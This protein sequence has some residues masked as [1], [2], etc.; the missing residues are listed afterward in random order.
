M[1]SAAVLNPGLDSLY[2][3]SDVK[4]LFFT[5][6][7]S[8]V[9]QLE[10][11]KATVQDPVN[12]E[13]D[14]LVRSELSWI[15]HSNVPD[16]IR[17]H[18]APAHIASFI[19][20]DSL[21]SVGIQKTQ[22]LLDYRKSKLNETTVELR[23]WMI[24]FI[25]LSVILLLYTI[26]NLFKQK[27]KTISKEKEL[28][29]VLNRISDGVVSV[30]N[31]WR[32]TFLNDAAMA[33]H[34][35][36]KEETLGK[37]IWDVH[38]GMKGTIFWDKYHEALHENKVVEIHDYYP[39]MDIWFSVK[40]YPSA[41]GLTIFYKDITESKKAEQQLTQ[42]LKE[43]T[44]YKFALDESSIVAITDQ[45]GII[46]HAND[47]F[48]KISKY[49]REELIGQDHRII[50]SGHHPKEFIRNLWVTIAH[51]KIWKG[52]LKNKAKDGTIYW[53]DTTIVPFLDESGKPYQY[54]AIRAD[55]TE[56]KNV[57]DN[58]ASSEMHFRSLI[59]NSAEGISLTDE[60]AN[61]IYRSP[62]AIKIMGELPKEKTINLAHPDDL[63]NM[64]NI[65]RQ[66]EA[67]P[68]IPFAF[69]CRFP[70]ASGHYVWLEG[71][72]TNLL[73]TKGVNAI[74]TNFRDITQRKEDEE[75][76]IKSEKI[77]KAI[78]SSIPGSVICLLDP[79]YRYLLIEGDMLEKLGYSKEVL[80]GNKAGDVLPPEIFENAKAD[81]KMVLEGKTI[82]RESN[83]LGY[84]I[85]SRLI[86]LKDDH[87]SVYAIMTV[88]IDVTQLKNAQRSI[89]ELN[90]DL[91]QKIQV[92]TTELKK[93]NE[94]LEAFSYS[95]SHD[96]RAPLRAIMGY[97]A[98][99][100]EDYGNKL[101]TEAKEII[102]VIKASSLKMGRLIDDL[103]A[104]SRMG[105]KEMY[106]TI[107]DSGVMVNEVREEI[108]AQRKKNAH[109]HW[110]IR[111][112]PEMQADLNMIRLVW[113]NLISN[114][115]KYTGNKDQPQIEIGAGRENGQTVFYV[116]D[117][118]AGFDELYKHKLFKVFQRLHNENEFEG[119]GVGLALVE[120]IISKHGGKVWAEGKEN[121]GASFYFSL[122][123]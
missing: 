12:E 72:L 21:I 113:I 45:K 111:P 100:E 6:S 60:F 15:I 34:P 16:S 33:T 91:E 69:Q 89:S 55:I 43:V 18:R 53:V 42:T 67:N 81:L 123:D 82:T 109:I 14:S 3:S 50:N 68:G 13:L 54:V 57:E 96:L 106:K 62:A 41:D 86:P 7:Q 97:A 115:V 117:N 58:L 32:Y 80:L 2:R 71:T 64:K 46:K 120:R 19:S 49:P 10:I 110:D 36:S 85:I 75:K 9:R 87:N 8:I 22:S 101:A 102:D 24:L 28:E 25:I 119:T 35:L 118:G 44:D 99:L 56:R 4:K 40:V 59:E 74:V 66:V 107:V 104:F 103:L 5:D 94:E 48:C 1:E 73:Q 92:R 105:K 116:K 76:L 121:E 90:R 30:D 122:P 70:H 65:Q 31:D 52:E 83:R 26:I 108:V 84:D 20:I 79:E 114:A 23:Y 112:L 93:S 39:P 17:Y 78:A 47:N 88:A 29:T 61:N 11:L 51:G 38:P 95:V 98:M 77:Y 37:V 63:E 27:S